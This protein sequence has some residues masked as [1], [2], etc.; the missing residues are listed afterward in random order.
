MKS[1]SNGK[2]NK[3]A[4][5]KRIPISMSNLIAV[6]TNNH[7]K[8]INLMP[9]CSASGR[10]N[11]E[12]L[13]LLVWRSTI[14]LNISFWWWHRFQIIKCNGWYKTRFQVNTAHK[15]SDVDYIDFKYLLW[16][17]QEKISK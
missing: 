11:A 2:L 13:S 14:V 4:L 3:N 12:L 8:L 10:I 9:T 5:S 1:V 7:F 15:F 6:S 16:L 17:I